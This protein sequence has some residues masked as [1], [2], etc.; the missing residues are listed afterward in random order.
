MEKKHNILL[1]S[2][3]NKK[4]GHLVRYQYKVRITIQKNLGRISLSLIK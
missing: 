1:L 3:Q 4:F 2:S